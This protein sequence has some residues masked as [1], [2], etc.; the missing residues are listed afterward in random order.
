MMSRKEPSEYEREAIQVHQEPFVFR[1]F[2]LA[3][4]AIRGLLCNTISLPIRVKMNICPTSSIFLHASTEAVPA[5]AVD[6]ST[7]RLKYICSFYERKMIGLDKG[8]VTT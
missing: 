6:S 8:R 2:S 5:R 7:Q 1:P 3:R 4:C